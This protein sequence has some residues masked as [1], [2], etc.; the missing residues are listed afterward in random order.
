MWGC[1]FH[2]Y[3]GKSEV[4]YGDGWDEP[5]NRTCP[6]YYRRLPWV[7]QILMDLEDY[8]RGALGNVMLLEAPYL[9]LLRVADVEQSKWQQA[10]ERQ[11]LES[12]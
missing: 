11:L 5:F 4:E 10:Q 7:Q 9:E 2:G 3:E 1:G 8:R 6:Q 12:G